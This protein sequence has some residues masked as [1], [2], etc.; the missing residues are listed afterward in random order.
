M[1]ETEKQKEEIKRELAVYPSLEEA[2]DNCVEVMEAEGV[3]GIWLNLWV[4]KQSP[5]KKHIC[6]CVP[7]ANATLEQVLRFNK[8]A[9]V[10]TFKLSGELI[11]IMKNPPN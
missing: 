2:L 4:D 11:V 3:L 9:K 10:L 1:E 8:Y 5:E 6:I 7:L